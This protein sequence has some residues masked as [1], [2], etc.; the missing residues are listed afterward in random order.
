MHSMREIAAHDAEPAATWPVQAEPAHL[1]ILSRPDWVEPIVLCLKD[2]ALNSGICNESG[3]SG[4]VIALTEAVTNAIVHG[5]FE[6]ASDLKEQGGD[7]FREAINQRLDNPR[8]VHRIVDV[9]VDY[10]ANRCVWT[11]TDEGPGFDTEKMLARLDSDEPSE[12][13]A[14]GRGIPMMR[15]FV[16][17]LSWAH[18]GRQVRLAMY[19]DEV[20]ERRGAR[21]QSFTA[22]VE[23]TVLRNGRQLSGMGR[24]L[25]ATGLGFTLDDPIKAG[26]IVRVNLAPREEQGAY[27]S[28]MVVRCRHIS[29]HFYETAVAFDQRHEPGV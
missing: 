5:N 16:D 24:D 28:G 25:S 27:R 11:V 9:R 7:A 29:G 15:A 21:R 12:V 1:R 14:A 26:E 2:R 6:L 18:G 13:L 20:A 23:L 17:E 19:T 22:P 4:L 10:E 8:Y 3:A